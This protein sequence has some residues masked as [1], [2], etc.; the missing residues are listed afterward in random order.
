MTCFNSS[1]T[2]PY[3]YV[4]SISTEVCT[5]RSKGEHLLQFP[6]HCLQLNIVLWSYRLTT[7]LPAIQPSHDWVLWLAVS[8]CH[9]GVQWPARRKT[10]MIFQPSAP[11]LKWKESG[12]WSCASQVG[13]GITIG[14]YEMCIYRDKLHGGPVTIMLCS[15]PQPRHQRV[16][17]T[18]QERYP[19]SHILRP[20]HIEHDHPSGFDWMP[21][22]ECE[23]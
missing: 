20:R 14:R 19:Q 23:N 4:V 16:A 7:Q 11:C 1:V 10:P 21:C 9:G 17:A 2:C 6:A 22:I 15:S 3:N 5:T 8:Y 12:Y 18:H 13:A